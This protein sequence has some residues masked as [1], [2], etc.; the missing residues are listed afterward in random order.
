MLNYCKGK[1]AENEEKLEEIIRNSTDHNSWN[2][3]DLLK[4]VVE[5]ILNRGHRGYGVEDNK[6]WDSA[7]ITEIDNGDYQGTKIFVFHRKCYQPSEVEYLFT[8]VDYG[9]C[10]CCDTLQ[11]IQAEGDLNSRLPS[12]SQVKD[13][14]TLCRDMVVRMKQPF[15]NPYFYLEESK[16]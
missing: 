8:Y 16:V 15:K 9:S 14:M 2:Y 7:D 5:N 13:Y 10:S 4:L 11:G 12:K 6:E 1:W 3:R